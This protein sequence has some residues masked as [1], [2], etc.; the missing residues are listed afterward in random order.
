MLKERAAVSF[1]RRV[2]E[3]PNLKETEV[4]KWIH[5]MEQVF[6]AADT[7]KMD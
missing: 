6:R 1:S 4:K 7:I 2:T 5:V 3:M